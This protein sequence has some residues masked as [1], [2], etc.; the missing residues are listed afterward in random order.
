[1]SQNAKKANNKFSN[2]INVIFNCGYGYFNNNALLLT[3]YILSYH[4]EVEITSSFFPNDQ[5]KAAYAASLFRFGSIYLPQNR[6]TQT[7]T[8][9]CMQAT[10]ESVTLSA[11][12]AQKLI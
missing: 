4:A 2:F 7:C 3:Y 9:V 1:M 6:T 11:S 8:Q 10:N 5:L 12:T